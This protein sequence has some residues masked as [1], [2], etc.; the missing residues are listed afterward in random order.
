MSEMAAL[1]DAEAAL[2]R[3]VVGASELSADDQEVVSAAIVERVLANMSNSE[4]VAQEDDIRSGVQTVIDELRG[5][6]L[7]AAA[8]SALSTSDV[9]RMLFGLCKRIHLPYPLCPARD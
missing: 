9:N 1:G 3:D 4:R 5:Q 8:P 6:Q 2:V 7:R